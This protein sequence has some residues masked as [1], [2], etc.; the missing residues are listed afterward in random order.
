MRKR[1]VLPDMP[2]IAAISYSGVPVSSNSRRPA[3]I[4][5]GAISILP[6]VIA[7][8]PSPTKNAP[9]SSGRKPQARRYFGRTAI[10]ALKRSPD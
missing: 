10:T 5:S 6:R 7:R 2:I 8:L 3:V 9:A 1:N 4:S